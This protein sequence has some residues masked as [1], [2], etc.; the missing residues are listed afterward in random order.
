MGGVTPEEKAAVSLKTFF[1]MVAVRIV[2]DHVRP[3]R[4]PSYQGTP[5]HATQPQLLV[6]RTDRPLSAFGSAAALCFLP[7]CSWRVLSAASDGSLHR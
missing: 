6:H 3:P 1:T 2:L 4:C 5:T 7:R